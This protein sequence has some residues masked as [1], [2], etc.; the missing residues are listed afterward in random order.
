M[1]PPDPRPSGSWSCL[2]NSIGSAICVC[3]PWRQSWWLF[4]QPSC[5][6]SMHQR[7]NEIWQWHLWHLMPS[8]NGWAALSRSFKSMPSFRHLVKRAANCSSNAS[9]IETL[10]KHTQEYK[11]STQ[12]KTK[13]LST[14]IILCLLP[15]K[16]SINIQH[17]NNFSYWINVT[18]DC[19]APP[20]TPWGLDKPGLEL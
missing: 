2:L 15:S 16:T 9:W 6:A 3:C 17:Q 19:T 4:T 14:I 7:E 1:F 8:D 13:M 5:N 10:K 20:Y 11:K 18:F 12:K